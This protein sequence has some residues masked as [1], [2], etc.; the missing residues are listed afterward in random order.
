MRP[1]AHGDWGH[2]RL[3]PNT[4]VLDDILYLQATSAFEIRKRVDYAAGLWPDVWE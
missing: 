3:S 1:R 2:W 4:Y